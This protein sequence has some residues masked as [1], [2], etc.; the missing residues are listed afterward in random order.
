MTFC[1]RSPLFAF[2]AFL[3]AIAIASTRVP[4]AES[5]ADFV[6]SVPALQAG[7]MSYYWEVAPAG[8]SIDQRPA[9][10]HMRPVDL[11]SEWEHRASGEKFY[12]MF[13]KIAYVVNKDITFFGGPRFSD[14][15]FHRTLARRGD[16]R[17]NSEMNF[18]DPGS[19]TCPGYDFTMDPLLSHQA[20]VDRGESAQAIAALDPTL[21]VPNV[22]VLQRSDHFGKLLGMRTSK[23]AELSYAYYSIAPGQTLVVNYAMT[24]LYAVP[25][26]MAGGTDRLR[27]EI[28]SGN[29]GMIDALEAIPYTAPVA[30]LP[31]PVSSL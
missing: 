9:Y 15:N 22:L 28:V 29:L 12:V 11:N 2:V 14:V 19:K 1:V 7:Q 17:Q 25:P 6:V 18:T 16:I 24:F 23:A 20:I 30:E 26:K 8:E 4:H 21:G 10:L 27:Q 13:T 5:S 31:V 3:P